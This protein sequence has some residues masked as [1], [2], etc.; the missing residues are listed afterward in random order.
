VALVIKKWYADVKPNANGNY[1]EISAR[2]SGLFA[3]FLSL[4]KIDPTYILHV[5]YD[6]ILSQSSSFTG[7]KKIFLLTRSVSSSYFGYHKPWKAALA[8]GAIS[9]FLGSA[10]APHSGFGGMTVMLIGFLIAAVYYF[11]NKELMI[12]FSEQNGDDYTWVLKRSAI[13]GKEINEQQ[14]ELVTSILNTLIHQ[15][16]EVTL[17]APQPTS[18]LHAAA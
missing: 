7:Y 16:N 9:F 17:A 5:S 8:I 10:I 3:W 13:E 6:Q 4:I 2:E 18:A 1:V 11:L 12:G 14:L 15:G